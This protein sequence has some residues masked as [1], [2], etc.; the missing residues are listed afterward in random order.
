MRVGDSD[1]AIKIVMNLKKPGFIVKFRFCLL[2]SKIKLKY[3]TTQGLKASMSGF[4][5]SFLENYML[6]HPVLLAFYL[7]SI[8]GTVIQLW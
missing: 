3:C 2:N 7:Y 4:Q 8:I 5:C 1:L 6:L